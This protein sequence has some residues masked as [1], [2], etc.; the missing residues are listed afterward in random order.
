MRLKQLPTF[1]KSL[2]LLLFLLIPKEVFSAPVITNVTISGGVVTVD[3]TSFGSHADF[4]SGE[5]YLARVWANWDVDQTLTQSGEFSVAGNNFSEWSVQTG[6]PTNSVKYI[7][8]N[9]V[10]TRL[11]ALE[12]DFSSSVITDVF[13]HR[14]KFMWNDFDGGDSD[15]VDGKIWRTYLGDNSSADNFYISTGG[16]N[17]YIRGNSE[18]QSGTT[19]FSSPN[20][21]SEDAWH[22]VEILYEY[23]SADTGYIKV[24]LDGVIQHNETGW[25]L[26]LVYDPDGHSFELCNLIENDDKGTFN[27]D[28]YYSSWTQARI[29]F[30]GSQNEIQIPLTWS[31]TQATA[32]FNQG[33]LASDETV[34]VVLIDSSGNE[35]NEYSFNL[36]SGGDPVS[37]SPQSGNGK[38]QI[39]GNN[40]SLSFV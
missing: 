32:T 10:S 24:W 29:E 33:E 37:P 27:Y 31:T 2:F 39:I 22:V 34:D 8:R 11:A 36:E 3:G 9:Y 13:Y 38:T 23:Q 40:I 25:F 19:W 26:D 6:G 20:Q 12:A 1:L 17:F 14:F 4:N 21:I 7:E 15:N 5:S 28:D 35:S 30:R 18:A 16:S